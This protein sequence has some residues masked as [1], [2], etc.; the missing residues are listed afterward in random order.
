M[1]SESGQQS[2]ALELLENIRQTP[3]EYNF[4]DVLRYLEASQADG[5]RLGESVKGSDDPVYIRQQPSMAFSPATIS[6]FVPGYQEQDQIFNWPYG[7]FGSNG[8]M[9]LHITEYAFERELH[10]GDDTFSR[11]A[12]VFHHRMVSFLYRAWANTQPTIEMD[13][14]TTNKFDQYVGAIA[15]LNVDVDKFGGGERDVDDERYRKLFRA[16][17]YNQQVRSADGLETLLS[18]FFKFPFYVSQYSGDW[19]PLGDKNQFRLGTYGYANGL[20]TTSC[21]GDKMY[22]C[23]NKFSLSTGVLNETQFE[24]LLPG[25]DSYKSL[26]E[27]VTSYVGIAFEWDLTLKIVA[28]EIPKPSL[29]EGAQLGL[30]LWLGDVEKQNID[31]IDSAQESAVP[32]INVL[33]V[34]LQSRSANHYGPEIGE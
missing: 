14:P 3:Y 30:N 21:L 26:Y 13:R 8:P 4:F 6:R 12:D 29:G 22:D 24:R 7:I 16:G 27:L 19:L 10:H 15:G 32:S 28:S 23:Q 25:G 20:G 33:E 1:A 31:E 9:P 11:F 2:F 34:N 18:G 5:P 17:L